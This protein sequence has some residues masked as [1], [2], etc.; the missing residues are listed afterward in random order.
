MKT[1]SLRYHLKGFAELL[2]VFN[3]LHLSQYYIYIYI[4]IYIRHLRFCKCVCA[5]AR[6]RVGVW[7]WV[8]GWVCE[9]V[10]GWLVPPALADL[11]HAFLLSTGARNA[12]GLTTTLGGIRCLKWQRCAAYYRIIL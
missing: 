12:Q 8:S 4:Y 7:V 9:W 6:V 5:L 2:T 11:L 1:V 10:G 3:C